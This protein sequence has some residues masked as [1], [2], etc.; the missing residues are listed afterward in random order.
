MKS[1]NI[2]YDF[3]KSRLRI[4]DILKASDVNYEEVNEIPARESLTFNNGFYVNCTALFVDIRKSTA[5]ASKHKRPILAKIYKAYISELVALINSSPLCVE[6]NIH[7]DSVWG[8]FNTAKKVNI[9]SVFGLAAQISSLIKILNYKLLQKSI[10]EIKVGIGIDY[11]RALML[12]AG[13]NGS[14]LNDVVWMGDVVNMASKLCSYGNREWYD[15]QLMVSDVI[16]SNLNDH[17]KGLLTYSTY[18]SCYQGDVLSTYMEE[19]YNKNC[20]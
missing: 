5:L 12:K 2:T 6:V 19:W 13:F 9:D 11:G 3:E 17:N 10:S 20:V 1:N 15:R 7:G 16:Y 18:R 14:G 4:D 8:V